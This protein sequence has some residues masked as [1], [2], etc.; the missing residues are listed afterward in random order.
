MGAARAR[1]TLGK[2]GNSILAGFCGTLAHTLLMA[3]KGTLG[4]LP[5]FQPY[6]DLQ[7]GLSGLL[8]AAVSPGMAWAVTL[9]NG[10][11]IWGFAFGKIYRFLPG[12]N[13]TQ[14]GVVFGLCAWAVMG[15]VF[16]PLLGRGLFARGLGLSFAPAA[17]MLAM[18][19]AYSVTM[20]LAYHRLN[21]RPRS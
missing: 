3:L 15:L 4:L 18:L 13:P 20:S 7:R 2:I 12:K 19:L 6:D 10:A 1:M 5:E 8:G 17:L 11:V 16:F 9:L 14:K 21:A